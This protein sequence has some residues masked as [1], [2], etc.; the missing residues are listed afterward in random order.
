MVH[1]PGGRDPGGVRILTASWPVVI[2]ALP[3]AMNEDTM[4]ELVRQMEALYARRQ[5]YALI[6]D[7]RRLVSVPGAKER[8]LLTDWLT[9]PDQIENQR[10]WNVGSS[11]IVPNA[12]LRGALQA[13]YWVWTAPNPQHVAGHLDDAWRFC[14]DALTKQGVPLPAPS[15]ELRRTA[16]RELGST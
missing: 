9:R 3:P 15:V 8:K 6:T 2:L 5:R 13:I 12:L 1:P 7:T 10:T 11:T 14:I 4:R 16:D